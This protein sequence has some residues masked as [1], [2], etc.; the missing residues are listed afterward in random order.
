MVLWESS[1][2]ESMPYLLCLKINQLLTI[3]SYTSKSQKEFGNNNNNKGLFGFDLTS[4][5]NN[6]IFLNWSN[7]C[8][9]FFKCCL[10]HYE[11]NIKFN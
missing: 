7:P 6:I 1:L 4:G 9:M 11:M 3:K 2:S 10:V 8:N 5:N